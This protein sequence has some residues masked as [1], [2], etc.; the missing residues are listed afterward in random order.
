VLGTSLFCLLSLCIA[1]LAI[2]LYLKPELPT[3]EALQDIRFQIPLKIYSRDEQ[4]IAEYGEQ[5]RTPIKYED[6]PDTFIKAVMAAEDKNFFEHS[7][8]DIKALMRAVK[9]MIQ[10]KGSIHGGGGSTITMQ[11]TRALFL[12][13]DRKFKRKFKEIILTVQLE[14]ELSKQEI[15]ELYFNEIYLGKRAYGIQAAANIYYDKDIDELTLAQLAMIAGLP[16]APAANNPVNNPEKAI[17]RRN[18]ILSRMLKLHFISEQQYNEGINEPIS[19]KDYGQSRKIQAPFVAEMIRQELYQQYGASIYTDGYKAYASID[20][21]LQQYANK[22]VYQGIHSYNE[23]HGYRGVISN[24]NDQR[25]FD[26][27]QQ[28]LQKEQSQEERINQVKELVNAKQIDFDTLAQETPTFGSLKPAVIIV[29][30][31][32]DGTALALMGE[33]E[34]VS[35]NKNQILWAAK[36]IDRDTKGKR[37]TKISEVLQTGDI[38]YLRQLESKEW[39]LAQKTEVQSA[40]VALNPNDGSILALVG[41]Y[42]YYENKYNRVIQGGRQ[43][44]SSLKPFLYASALEHG[45]T[46]ASMINDAPVVFN[47]TTLEEA[48]RPENSGGQFYGPTRFRKALYRSRNLVSIRILRKI[49]IRNTIDYLERFGFNNTQLPKDL[50]LS[51]GSASLSPLQIATGFSTFANGGHRIYPY[52][53]SRLE[54]TEGEILFQATP[55]VACIECLNRTMSIPSN[56][57]LSEID[58]TLNISEKNISEI[59]TSKTNTDTKQITYTQAEQIIEPR[60]NYIMDSIL[61]DVIKRGTGRKALA[62]KRQDIR[63]KTGTTNDQVDAWFTGYNNNIVA[64]VWVG[65]DTPKTLGR[66]EYGAV[67]ALPIWLNFMQKALKNTQQTQLARPDKLVTVKINSET[68]EAAK[69]SE[70]NAIFEIFREENAP[71]L[72]AEQKNTSHQEITEEVNLDELF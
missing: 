35:F 71:E 25:L 32:K 70:E 46:A 33:Q 47:D 3:L 41:G 44:G 66:G 42:N 40:F 38:V 4:L 34:I 12:N 69:P 50:S 23:R 21:E 39:R 58:E 13:K 55:A 48:W 10:N 52:Y 14:Q 54:N 29:V 63:G 7:G 5:R 65:F 60:V 6:V 56:K 31:D 19:A 16:K 30:N 61:G 17:V 27:N 64:S 72:S 18:W 8:V 1:V 15:L 9:L 22:A 62:L 67:A 59:N 24:I 43:A 53:L 51:L 57:A 49:G 26:I 2:Y 20:S 28:I 68:G 36:Y 45:Y 11:L 37:P